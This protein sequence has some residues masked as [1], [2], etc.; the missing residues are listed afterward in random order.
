MQLANRLGPSCTFHE[1]NLGRFYDSPLS[2]QD[3]EF[4]P[5]AMLVHKAWVCAY[6]Q[7]SQQHIDFGQIW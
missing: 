7:P 4:P 5:E 1:I 3:A 6:L 2:Y